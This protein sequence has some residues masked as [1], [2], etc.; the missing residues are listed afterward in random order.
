MCQYCKYLYIIYYTIKFTLT[1]VLENILFEKNKMV[2]D[3]RLNCW[4]YNFKSLREM[5]LLSKITSIE[6][7]SY[8]IK[9]K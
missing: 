3:L 1:F 7:F 6:Y 4:V 8:D 2:Y 9:F 5:S